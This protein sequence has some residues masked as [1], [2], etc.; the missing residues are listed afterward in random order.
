MKNKHVL[1]LTLIDSFRG[2]NAFST[3][4]CLVDYVKIF[5]L[6]RTVHVG[7]SYKGHGIGYWWLLIKAKAGGGIWYEIHSYSRCSLRL[8]I[9]RRPR[10]FH[11]N[12]GVFTVVFRNTWAIQIHWVILASV[13]IS[14]N[15]MWSMKVEEDVPVYWLVEC[16]PKQ[17]KFTRRSR[18]LNS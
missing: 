16:R 14:V 11:S 1:T 8:F 15:V 10:R 18:W 9:Q 7:R 6:Y 4:N 3:N 13:K 12:G 2:F 5:V 17:I